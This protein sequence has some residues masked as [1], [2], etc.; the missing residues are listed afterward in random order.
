MVVLLSCDN[1]KTPFDYIDY[2]LNS[3]QDIS[4][5]L[6][7]KKVARISL[8]KGRNVK[9][10]NRSYAFSIDGS[11]LFTEIF[12]DG[13]SIKRKEVRTYHSN[14][15][16]ASISIEKLPPKGSSL[17]ILDGKRST[18]YENGFVKYSG[19]YSLNV[20]IDTHE[21]FNEEGKLK[22]RM[23]F[24]KEGNCICKQENNCL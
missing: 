19:N 8:Y 12:I 17:P 9:E 24:D 6:E 7:N 18:F 3:E 22:T 20:P 21:Y 14:G 1:I 2:P 11:I 4:I 23:I 13:D 15:H 16:L 5:M 10:L